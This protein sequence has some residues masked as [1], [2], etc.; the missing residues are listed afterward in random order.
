[1][2][3]LEIINNRRSCK[4][5]DPDK[6]VPRDIVEKIADAGKHAATGMNRQSP[7][8]LVVENKE[9]RDKLE[10]LNKIPLGTQSPTFYGAPQV[11][12]VLAKKDVSTHVYDGSIVMANMMIAAEAC[13]VGSCWIHRARETFDSSAGK[14]IL[15]FLGIEGEWEGIGHLV[16]GYLK[17][18]KREAIKYKEDYIMWVD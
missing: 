3:T 8:I 10:E 14:E 12:V 15:S 18:P 6:K 11:L 5:Y 16:I 7:M 2:D 1:M 17:G 13:G 4:S 9:L